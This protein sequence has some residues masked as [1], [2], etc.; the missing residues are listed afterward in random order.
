MNYNQFLNNGLVKFC[1]TGNFK[2]HIIQNIEVI[3]QR[4]LAI[5]GDEA[6]TKLLLEVLKSLKMKGVK[7]PEIAF[8]VTIDQRISSKDEEMRFISDLQGM[9]KSVYVLVCTAFTDFEVDLSNRA[10]L[11]S[12]AEKVAISLRG[13]GFSDDDFCLL[14]KPFTIYSICSAFYKLINDFAENSEKSKSAKLAKKTHEQL[15]SYKN[16]HEGQRVFLVGYRGVK[17]DEF[18]DIMNDRTISYN[19]ICN[20]FSK[21]PQRPLYYLL[22]DNDHYQGNGK[23]IEGMECF[24]ATDV[25]VFEAKFTKQPT[26]LNVISENLVKDLPELDV[27]RRNYTLKKIDDLYYMLQMAIFMG[28]NEIYIYGFDELY[29]SYLNELEESFVG[30]SGSV[31]A[32]PE[33]AQAVLK[34]VN[35][36]AISNNIKIYNLCDKDLLDVFEHKELADVKINKSKI[37]M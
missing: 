26:Y 24:V 16:K 7:V 4:K 5:L 19:G 13:I 20:I 1:K 36:Y 25:N 28:F 37:L 21:T 3:G 23:Y 17:L 34:A 15:M 33:Q 35:D 2:K 10:G 14:N 29:S 11:L 30:E 27:V 12:S 22:S 31:Y 6:D 32:F 9:E 18:N 8:H